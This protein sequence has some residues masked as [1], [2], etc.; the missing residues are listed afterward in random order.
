MVVNGAFSKN[1]C[2]ETHLGAHFPEEYVPFAF[3]CFLNCLLQLVEVLLSFPLVFLVA[4]TSNNAL[5]N[6][7]Q[8]KVSTFGNTAGTWPVL[9]HSNRVCD[10]TEPSKEHC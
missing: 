6:A 7:S 9:G 5:R 2:P 3:L 4:L 1:N 8:R 10:G